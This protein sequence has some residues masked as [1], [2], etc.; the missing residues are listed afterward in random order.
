M[1][2]S[3][4]LV[5]ITVLSPVDVQAKSVG[6]FSTMVSCFKAHEYL[7]KGKYPAVGTQLVCVKLEV[8]DS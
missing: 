8:K 5:A 6:T 4:M 1:I 3:W 7:L 2:Y